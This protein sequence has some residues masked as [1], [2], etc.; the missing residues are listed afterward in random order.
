MGHLKNGMLVTQEHSTKLLKET[1]CALSIT[2]QTRAALLTVQ[3]F[4]P[5]LILTSVMPHNQRNIRLLAF[6]LALVFF[7]A[8]LH[9]CADLTSAPSGTHICPVCSAVGAAVVTPA[10]SITVVSQVRP[11]EVFAHAVA[12]SPE[13]RRATSPRAPPV[14]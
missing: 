12:N 4:Q 5:K 10:P 8:Q 2:P 1:T 9:Y 7:G 13:I 11:L 6:L 3:P 14:I